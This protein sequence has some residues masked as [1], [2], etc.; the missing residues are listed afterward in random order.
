MQL[1]NSLKSVKTKRAKPIQSFAKGT[2]Q[3]IKIQFAYTIPD[4][5]EALP[6]KMQGETYQG[7]KKILGKKQAL[8]LITEAGEKG[9]SEADIVAKLAG[10]NDNALATKYAKEII[11]NNATLRKTLEGLVGSAKVDEYFKHCMNADRSDVKDLVENLTKDVAE[12]LLGKKDYKSG[13]L[14]DL[15]IALKEGKTINGVDLSQFND[16]TMNR[17]GLIGS[18]WPYNILNSIGKKFN[19]GKD[20][21]FTKGSLGD[22]LLKYN[23]AAGK[24]A[25]TA[26]G[27]VTQNLLLI[28]GESVSNFCCDA[29]GMNFFLLPMVFDLFNTAQ[30]APK[31]QK[32]STVANDFAGSIGSL[33]VTMPLASAATYGL[34]SLKN[35]DKKDAT[36]IS[37]YI[38][39]PIGNV[40][41]MGLNKDANANAKAMKWFSKNFFEKL[42]NTGARWGG[43]LLRFISIMFIFQ[44]IFSKPVQAIIQKIFGKPYDKEAA[45]QAKQLEAQKQQVIPE[46]GITQGEL[47][48]KIEKNPAALQKLQ[49]DAKLMQAM[50]IDP[51]ILLDLLDNKPINA[52]EIIA[53][54]NANKGKIISPA[55]K[56]LL[57]NRTNLNPNAQGVA[58]KTPQNTNNTNQNADS[59]TYIPSSA[60]VASSTTLSPE[61]KSKYDALMAS[62]DK[63]LKAAE[64]YI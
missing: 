59:A 64:R 46:L 47:M 35:I 55:N 5:L 29:A 50:E 22:A 49:T 11:A 58:S 16:I 15:L 1:E 14:S 60:F 42:G 57:S 56:S 62:S 31:G 24:T 39:K 28:P 61:Q 7:L 48:E 32:V 23:V 4:V 21:R 43:G 37:K 6:L 44:P 52:D 20:I 45:E 34:A 38:L 40:F 25:D 36:F 54:A 18:W 19:G 30:D 17:E 63:A 12:H 51:K 33:M 3:G 26:L 41:G 53:R 9:L 10:L 27:K 13:E 8:K 2:G